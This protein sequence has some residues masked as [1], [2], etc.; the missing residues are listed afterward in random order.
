MSTITLPI[1]LDLN[2]LS[3]E[4]EARVEKTFNGTASERGIDIDYRVTRDPIRLRMIGAG[5]HASTTVRYA[6][7]ACRGRFPCVS[8]GFAEARREAEI[9]LHT[10]L[11]WD[12]AWRLRS[13]TT[14][15]PVHYPKPCEV[16][17][18]GLDITRR[19]VAP[20]VERQL[21]AAARIID[22][23]TPAVTNIRPQAEQ[24]WT[25]LQ[26]PFELA[27]RT[28]LVMEPVDVALTPI[29]GAGTIAT[30][31]L[32]LRALTK[33]VVGDRPAAAR[34]PLPPLRVAPPPGDGVR[35]PLD[36]ELPYDEASR[37]ASR[38]Y[39]GR[40]YSVDG[41]P[42]TIESLRLA[43]AA[44]GRIALEAM[45]DYRGGVLRNYRGIVHLQGTPQFDPAT[46]MLFVPDLD[47]ALDPNR[48][49]FFTR[50]VEQAA[51]ESIRQRLRESARL[52]LA[53]R[54]AEIR[55]EISRALTR[56]LAPGVTLR[57]TAQEIEPVAVHPGARTITIRIIATGNAAV[58]IR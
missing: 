32:S 42:L 35:I 47:Y 55:S 18:F 30:S 20:V 5:L 21:G 8:C 19:F 31:T 52:P 50:V 36:L 49:G 23:N 11:E 22:R 45:I 26:T 54:I 4:I 13:S 9:T 53:G 51:H 3:P 58:E 7:Q 2:S 48:R 44:G 28:W 1:R 16:T 40:T 46:S 27:P 29:T 37:L 56:P 10:K 12:P 39:A 57:G 38:E 17:W 14:L 34:K 41:K 24:I 15:L 33:V 25:S 43:P 6:M